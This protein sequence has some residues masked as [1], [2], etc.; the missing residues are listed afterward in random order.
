MT[1]RELL[2][3][4]ELKSLTQQS[5]CA[6]AEFGCLIVLS[7]CLDSSSMRLGVP[8]KALRQLGAV[9]INKEG[10]PCLLSSG[11]P[12]SPVRHRTVTVDG[13]VPISF[14][15]WRRRPLQLQAGW[16]TV[17][18][19]VHTGQSGAPS[20]RWSG[21]RIARGLRG[22]PLCWRPLA[23]RTVWCTTIQSGEL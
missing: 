6:G 19:L 20:D 5:E 18:C 11:A 23:H 13:P 3:R 2:T 16:R 14:L 15:F 17:H 22:Q 9:K 12:D 4:M 7:E 10:Y 21:P 1:H 8:F